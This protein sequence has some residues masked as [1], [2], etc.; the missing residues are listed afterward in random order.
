MAAPKKIDY[1][2][3]E[4]EWRAGIK[5]PAQLASEYTVATGI[6][7]SHAAIIKHFKK[8]GVPRDLAA[9]VKA[10][11]DSMVMESMVTGKVST[12]TTK[13][14]AE[15]ID[16]S[17]TI[18]ANVQISHRQDASRARTLAMSLLAELEAETGNI[19]LFEQLGE[20]LRS[21]D[22]KG[23]DKRNDLYQKVI[24]GAGR[25][26]SMKKLADTLK[27]LIGLEREAYGLADETPPPVAPSVVV[28]NAPPATLAEIKQV[29][30]E[31]A[32]NPKV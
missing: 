1:E 15:L 16:H 9:K 7:V 30:T 4:P 26:D 25:I 28:N 12:V 8:L 32:A 10:K 3:I 29:L 23:Q 31:N 19:E 6:S 5:S 13:R 27:T 11:A 2:R 22:E 14:D 17:A 21:D 18:V 20:M 24:S